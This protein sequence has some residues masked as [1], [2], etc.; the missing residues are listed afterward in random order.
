MQKT[1][2][3]REPAAR[4]CIRARKGCGAWILG[5]RIRPLWELI[6]LLWEAIWLLWERIWL[7]WET[8]WLLSGGVQLGTVPPCR[9]RLHM[10]LHVG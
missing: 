4:Q 7:H 5:K 9:G 10:V 3:A 6:W 8:I 1:S 2:E